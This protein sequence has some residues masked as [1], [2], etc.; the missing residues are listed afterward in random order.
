MRFGPSGG[1]DIAGRC[2]PAHTT[3]GQT[4]VRSASVTGPG[5][6]TRGAR[7]RPHAWKAGPI[8]LIAGGAAAIVAIGVGAGVKREDQQLN[9]SAVAAWASVGAAAIGSG[10]AWWVVSAK[11]RRKNGGFRGPLAPE[12]ALHPTKIDLRLRF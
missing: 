8:I 7:G 6:R 1:T 2:E 10:V 4:A 5:T 11:R 12:L 9:A 3:L